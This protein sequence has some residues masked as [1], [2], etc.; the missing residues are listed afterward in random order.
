MI[1]KLMGKPIRFIHIEK[2]GGTSVAKFLRDNNVDFLIGKNTKGVK[3]H[4]HAQ[5]FENEDSFKFCVVRNPYTRLVSFYD[6]SGKKTFDC[7]WRDFV[8]TKIQQNCLTPQVM[9]IHKNIKDS[10]WIEN[11]TI[12]EGEKAFDWNRCLV[13]KIFKLENVDELKNFLNIQSKFPHVNKST[14]RDHMEYYNQELRDI[15]YDYYNKD[16]EL[17]GYDK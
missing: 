5:L 15:V 1:N 7:S 14:A 17:L 10:K 2:S 9:K 12:R 13:D 8:K 11:G 6:Y 16:F 3:K 4:S